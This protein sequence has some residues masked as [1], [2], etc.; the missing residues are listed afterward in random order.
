MMA[1][2]RPYRRPCDATAKI[3]G[4]RTCD[5]VCTTISSSQETARLHYP[6]S[7]GNLAKMARQV[8]L[9]VIVVRRFK[10]R[11]QQ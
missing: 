3:G 4:Y 5:P 6:A 10:D 2:R 1:P 7:D 11:A 8:L 9:V